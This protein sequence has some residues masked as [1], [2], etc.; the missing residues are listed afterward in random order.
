MKKYAIEMVAPI[1]IN[2]LQ[3]LQKQLDWDFKKQQ[4]RG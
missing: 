4:D 3:D 2:N 1:R